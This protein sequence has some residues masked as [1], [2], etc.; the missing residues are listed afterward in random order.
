MNIV[1]VGSNGLLGSAIIEHLS[2]THHVIGLD[3]EQLNLENEL[4]IKPVLRELQ[5]DI[6]INAAAMVNMELC[7]KQRDIALRINATAPLHMASVCASKQA[8]FIHFSSEYVFGGYGQVYDETSPARPLSWYGMTKVV[9]EE[10]IP[11][12]TEDYLIIRTSWLFGEGR[13]TVLDKAIAAGQT[14]KVFHAVYDRRSKPTYTKDLARA[15]PL[16]FDARGVVH[17]AN[18]E[19]CSW[20]SFVSLAFKELGL[21]TSLVQPVEAKEMKHLTAQRPDVTI[22]LT[23]KF[24]RLAGFRPRTWQEAL[25]EYIHARRV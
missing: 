21:D 22:L 2:K 3:R 18:S 13:E 8:K 9:A 11:T 5:F 16:L 4:E 7:E 10:E 24:A 23:H 12:F 19:A 6:L 1:V 17:F 15:L 25:K 20:F 14:G